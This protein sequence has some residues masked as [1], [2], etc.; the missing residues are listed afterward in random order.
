MNHWEKA[1]HLHVLNVPKLSG[2]FVSGVL[3]RL[4]HSPPSRKQSAVAKV[5]WFWMRPC[6][7][8]STLSVPGTSTWCSLPLPRLR[9]KAEVWSTFH[10]GSVYV[11]LHIEFSPEQNLFL[12][13]A[14]CSSKIFFH[15]FFL[16]RTIQK[17]QKHTKNYNTQKLKSH[18]IREKNTQ[19]DEIYR[20]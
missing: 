16:L 1:W 19:I 5:Q 18:L 12:I 15:L 4:C 13:L 2:G 9:A 11:H 6:I 17:L 7:S 20:F 3:P 8:K 10:R 14:I